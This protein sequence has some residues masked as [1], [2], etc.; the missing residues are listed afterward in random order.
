M[1][2]EQDARAIIEASIQAVLPDAA[3]KRTLEGWTPPGPVY[4]VAIGKAAWRM[5]AAASKSLGNAVY[6]GVVVTKYGHS[7]GAIPR[8]QIIEAGHP[9]PDHHALLGAH[10]ALALVDGLTAGDWVLFLVSG[11]GSAL[12]ELPLRGVSLADIAGLTKALLASGANIAEVNTVRKH[13]S[14]VKGGRFAQRCH[15]A[16]VRSVVLSDVLGDALDSIASGPAYPDATTV[17]DA[18]AVLQRYGINLPPHMQ[19]ALQQETPKALAHVETQ[20]TGNVSALCNA[21]MAAARVRGYAPLLMTTTLD[22]E[23]REAGACIAAM[24][25]EVRHSGHPLAPPCALVFGGE[26]VVRLQGQGKGGRNQE[27]ALAAAQ[28]IDGLKD[29]L[30]FSVGSD[31]TD[32]PTDAAGGMV[33]GEFAARCRAA[34]Y[35]IEAHLAENDSYPLLQAMGGLMMTG[36]TGTN[37]NDLMMVLCG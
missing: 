21:A 33:T 13:L 3:V 1:N 19:G 34:G 16:R 37:V 36:P 7:L 27:L 24:A 23:A 31:G 29:V 22:A 2:L 32:G 17:E 8:M 5:A 18:Q 28:G 6:A 20:I 26:T 14:A 9:V 15:P 10:K 4:V 30:V 11:G 25:R 12:F 35:S